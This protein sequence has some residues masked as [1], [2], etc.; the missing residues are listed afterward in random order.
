MGRG[1]SENRRTRRRGGAERIRR[2]M[3]QRKEGKE[4]EK[5]IKKT[6]GAKKK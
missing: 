3:G 6:R 4:K 2:R 5:E 1:R